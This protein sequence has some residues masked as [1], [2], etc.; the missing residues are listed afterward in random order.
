MQSEYSCAGN[1]EKLR[2][3]VRSMDSAEPFEVIYVM[4]RV[5]PKGDYSFE[6]IDDAIRPL[7]FEHTVTEA[8]AGTD[9]RGDLYRRKELPGSGGPP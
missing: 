9:V 5:A 7:G 4:S 8:F 3:I 2:S 6:F 1:I